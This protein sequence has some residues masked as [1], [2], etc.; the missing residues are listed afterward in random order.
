MKKKKLAN[1]KNGLGRSWDAR[2]GALGFS[3]YRRYC[4]WQVTCRITGRNRAG[5][6]PGV[7]SQNP[8]APEVNFWL[9]SKCSLVLNKMR[10]N[11]D[12]EK[13]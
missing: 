1:Q 13:K 9:S 8:P 5:R 3:L 2:D 12:K 7:Q 10:K 6:V 4:L 11:K